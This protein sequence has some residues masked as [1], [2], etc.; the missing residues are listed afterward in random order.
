MVAVAIFCDN[1]KT[2]VM[3]KDLHSALRVTAKAMA[4]RDIDYIQDEEARLKY[5]ERAIGLM[6]GT[7]KE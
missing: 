2:F 5:L 3:G 1:G 6:N 7:I 4:N